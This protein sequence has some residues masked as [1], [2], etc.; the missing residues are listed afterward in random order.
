MRSPPQSAVDGS[1]SLERDHGLRGTL[2]RLPTR[3]PQVPDSLMASMVERGPRGPQEFHRDPPVRWL[4]TA[5]HG[6]FHAA[7]IELAAGRAGPSQV[8]R[9][10]VV[11]TT[12]VLLRHPGTTTMEALP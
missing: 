5:I 9:A 11:G 6:I 4:F 10:M 3:P 8:Q 12:L 7:V 1:V 2:T